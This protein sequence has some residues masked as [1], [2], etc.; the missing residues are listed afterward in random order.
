MSSTLDHLMLFIVFVMGKFVSLSMYTVAFRGLTKYTLKLVVFVRINR[1]VSCNLPTLEILRLRTDLILCFKIV[2]RLIAL[3]FSD[4]FEFDTNHYNTRGNSLK[5][6]LPL[7]RNSVRKNFFAVRVVPPWNSLHEDVVMASDVCVF[8]SK[9]LYT[10]LGMF[11]V[12]T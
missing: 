6:K 5:L 12:R 3:N 10:D 11:A 4:F 7:A 1:L 2:H 9:L 8:K